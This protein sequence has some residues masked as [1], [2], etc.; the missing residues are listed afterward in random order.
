MSVKLSKSNSKLGVIPS[1]NLPPITT[2]RPGCPCAKS[3]YATKGRFRFPNVIDSMMHNYT[4][5]VARPGQYFDDICRQINTGLMSYSYFRWHASGDIV[6]EPYFA[7]MV[8]VAEKLPNT[9]FLVFTKKFEIVNQYISE[10]KVIPANLH[11]VLSAWGT[12]LDVQN[13]YNLPV[14]YVR[15]TNESDNVLIPDDA[16]E[17]LGN[18]QSCLKCWEIQHGQSVV[19]NLH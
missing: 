18:C 14:A 3:C 13:P 11:I 4:E 15:F 19:F 17:C 10:G 6:D 5:Y 16:E 1:I 7:G 8:N 12:S 2:C 9:S